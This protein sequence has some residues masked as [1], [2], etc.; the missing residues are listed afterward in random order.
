[1]TVTSDD[2]SWLVYPVMPDQVV[3]DATDPKEQVGEATNTDSDIIVSPVQLI[4]VLPDEHLDPEEVNSKVPQIVSN[5]HDSV[6]NVNV[7]D[8][9]ESPPRSTRGIPQRR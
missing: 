7:P 9:Y 6:V 1:M 4:P 8:R 5:N 2:L 3:S